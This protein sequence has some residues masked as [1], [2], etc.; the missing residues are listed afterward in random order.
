MMKT[1]TFVRKTGKDGQ[2]HLDISVETPNA[3]V[4]ITVVLNVLDKSHENRYDFEDLAGRL[5][6]KGDAVTQQR[7]LRDGWQ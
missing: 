3:N 1:L 4:E 2:L 6:W 7:C 5:R